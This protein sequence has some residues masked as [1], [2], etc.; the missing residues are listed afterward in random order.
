MLI[1]V[2]LD[3]ISQYIQLTNRLYSCIKTVYTLKIKL[4]YRSCTCDFGFFFCFVINNYKTK[5]HFEK[6][7]HLKN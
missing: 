2:F 4:F 1:H 3:I 5:R 6:T 7:T